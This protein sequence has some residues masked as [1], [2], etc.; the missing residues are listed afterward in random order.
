MSSI[1]SIMN[2]GNTTSVSPHQCEFRVALDQ[3]KRTAGLTKLEEAEFQMT[4]LKELQDC[5]RKIQQ[6]QEQKRKMMYMKRLDP[7]LQTI[8]QYG[9]VLDVFVNTSDIVAFIWGPMKFILLIAKTFSDALHSVLD[10]YQSI[11]EQIPLLRGYEQLFSSNTHMKSVLLLIYQ[12][13]L[14]FHREAIKHFKQRLW[15]QLFQATWRGFTIK[16]EHLKSNLKRHKDLI[17]S[18]ATIVQFE[19]IQKIREAAKREFEAHLRAESDRRRLR[20]IQWLS[21]FNTESLQEEYRETRSVCNNS[22]RWMI[23]DLRF[24][25]W[26]NPSRCLWPSLWINGIP[27]AGKTILSSVIVDELRRVTKASAA[28]FYCKYGDPSRNTFISVARSL[29]AQLL[30]QNDNLLQLLYEKASMGGEIELTSKATAKELLHAALNDCGTTYVVLDGID[31]CDRENRKELATWFQSVVDEVSLSNIGAIRCLFVSQDDGVARNDLGMIPSIK[32]VPSGNKNDLQSFADFWNKRIEGRFGSL[33]GN[34]N[35]ANIIFARA[36]GMFLFARLLAEHLFSQSSRENLLHELH[37]S[38]LPVKL[39]DAYSRILHRITE[40][41]AHGLTQEISMVLGWIVCA[42]RPLRWREIQGAMSLDIEKQ[43][44]NHECRL[45]DSP[46]DLFASFIEVRPNDTVELIHGTAREYLIRSEIVAPI[47]T[48]FSLAFLTM[49]FLEFPELHVM[50]AKEETQNDILEGRLAFYDYASACWSLHVQAG[51]PYPDEPGRLILL[52]ETLEA[53]VDLHWSTTAKSLAV[54]KTTQ[55]SL[56]VLSQ[57]ESYNKIAQAVTWSKKQLSKSGQGPS[58][59]EAL[60]LRQVTSQLRAVLESLQLSLAQ[61]EREI[62]QQYYGARWFKCPRINCF[63]Y[64]E[65]FSTSDERDDHIARHERPFMCIVDGCYMATFGCVTENDLKTHLFEHHGIDL[66]DNTEF[67]KPRKSNISSSKVEARYNCPLCPKKFTRK[68]NLKSHLRTHN[69]EK[70]FSCS[71]C[72][73]KFTRYSDCSRHELGHGE[74]KFKCS[75]QL[76]DGT[77]WGCKLTFPRADKLASHLRSK[78]GV[79]CIRP[80]IVQ[81][82]QNGQQSIDGA[83][84]PVGDLDAD[85]DALLSNV[86]G[87]PTF[88]EFLQ[89]CCLNESVLESEGFKE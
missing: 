20:V 46:K 68:F 79:Q 32:I 42:P 1:T 76:Q 74:K 80:L 31:E 72:K 44:I 18:H 53:F 81:E 7:F 17:E 75:G 64:H 13:I 15:K 70:P 56:R 55:E 22:G 78:R 71:V 61:D 30:A 28:F 87:L 35:I 59:D 63:F 9:K 86:D 60:D 29:L 69:D 14:E 24:Q 58:E 82:L 8:E 34:Y 52:I 73:E 85:T 84:L 51:L 48:H 77:S 6:E 89:L 3:F 50:R 40:N 38:K 37:P 26:F 39:D 12:D 65:G 62:L 25:K 49:G 36:Q 66:V 2:N 23:D 45:L 43:E 88:A 41:K 4:N 33:Q 19:E 5:V 21:P 67:P 54:S 83:G 16:I 47:K 27:G 11:G 10:A 57:S